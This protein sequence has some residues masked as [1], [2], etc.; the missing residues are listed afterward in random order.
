MTQPAVP[1]KRPGFVMDV[2]NGAVLGDYADYLG[3]MGHLTMIVCGFIPVVGTFSAI[4]DFFA[5]RRKR[6][7]FGAFLNLLAL[8]PV[9][10]GFAKAALV[11]RRVR[12]VGNAMQSGNNSA[13]PQQNQWS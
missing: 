3:A 6:D 7:G 8:V 13:T 2:F 5:C 1:V 11:F 4:R 12:H 9:L 10:G